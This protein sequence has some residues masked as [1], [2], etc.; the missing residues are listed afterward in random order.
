MLHVSTV[1]QS[2]SISCLQQVWDG[3]WGAGE[4][5]DLAHLRR[6]RGAGGTKVLAPTLLQGRACGVL[7]AGEPVQC[8]QVPVNAA[9]FQH[10]ENRAFQVGT[11]ALRIAR[12]ISCSN[13]GWFNL[14]KLTTLGMPDYLRRLGLWIAHIKCLKYWMPTAAARIRRLSFFHSLI[15][16]QYI[17]LCRLCFSLSFS[18]SHDERTPPGLWY[19]RLTLTTMTSR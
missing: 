10:Q 11:L 17:P 12:S 2:S 4:H 14:A 3:G 16:K 8:C 15:G 9:A 13:H 5:G 19:A 1:L 7:P 18:G 6:G